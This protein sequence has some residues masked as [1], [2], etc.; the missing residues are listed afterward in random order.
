MRPVPPG[1]TSAK[2]ADTH[3]GPGARASGGAPRG[4]GPA[5]PS[6]CKSTLV[7]PRASSP[8][9]TAAATSSAP[10]RAGPGSSPA[11]ATPV[12]RSATSPWSPGRRAGCSRP[13][14]V[15]SSPALTAATRGSG[16]VSPRHPSWSGTRWPPILGIR[17]TCSRPTT[18]T[19]SSRR[20][21]TAGSAGC[22]GLRVWATVAAGGCWRS[23]RPTRGSSTRARAHIARPGVGARHCLH[24]AS[25]SHTTAARPGRRLT[26]RSRPPSR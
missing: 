11:R 25:T 13:P 1:S 26:T 14:A 22:R 24:G 20:A 18:G 5:S 19:R 23:R 8:T 17:G 7:T 6:I 21:A 12:P 3:G 15:A 10:M 2:T 4:C 9:T 16:G